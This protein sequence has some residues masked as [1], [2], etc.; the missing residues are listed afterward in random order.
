MCITGVPSINWYTVEL[1]K[2]YAENTGNLSKNNCIFPGC[3]RILL[4]RDFEE[5]CLGK[6]RDP[7]EWKLGVEDMGLQSNILA[8]HWEKLAVNG[9]TITAEPQGTGQ[10]EN[11][12]WEVL[13]VV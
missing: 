5:L 9:A 12:A 1:G 13:Y 4:K 6:L 10:V 8:T 11:N 7:K 3:F 2:M